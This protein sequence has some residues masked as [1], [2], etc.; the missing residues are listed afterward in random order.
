MIPEF[1]HPC[2]HLT[3]KRR[4]LSKIVSGDSKKINRRLDKLKELLSII[5]DLRTTHF[6]ERNNHSFVKDGVRQEKSHGN[7]IVESCDRRLEP[8]SKLY[9]AVLYSTVKLIDRGLCD[10]KYLDW[11]INF[12]NAFKSSEKEVRDAC[13]SSKNEDDSRHQERDH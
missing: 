5:Q 2:D 7:G 11:A 6:D 3:E 9:L 12:F 10:E 4:S 1:D 13:S 8:S